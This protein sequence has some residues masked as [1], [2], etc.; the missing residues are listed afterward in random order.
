MADSTDD[1][2]FILDCLATDGTG[3]VS[4]GPSLDAL[5]M[6][7]VVAGSEDISEGSLTNRTCLLVEF[8]VDRFPT[9]WLLV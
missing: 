7:A 6:E 4:L 8:S 1:G 5:E 2:A 9:C 3:L